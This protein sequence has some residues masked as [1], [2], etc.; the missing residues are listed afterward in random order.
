VLNV[1]PVK[2]FIASIKL[3]TMEFVAK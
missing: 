3:Q 2:A 1:F